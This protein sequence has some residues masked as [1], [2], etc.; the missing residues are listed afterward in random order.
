MKLQDAKLIS[1]AEDSYHIEMPSGRTLT[2]DKSK[3]SEK[4][5]ALVRSLRPPDTQKFDEGG[6]VS[7]RPL[8]AGYLKE[9]NSRYPSDPNRPND[10]HKSTRDIESDVE[11]SDMAPYSNHF[12]D[13]QLK[14]VRG[15]ADGGEAQNKPDKG[16]SINPDAAKKFVK[17]FNKPHTLA[18]GFENAKKELGFAD[19][20]EIPQDSPEQ[21]MAD[22]GTAPSAGA[23]PEMQPP[24]SSPQNPMQQ[25][26]QSF[27]NGLEQQKAGIQAGA[28]IAAKEGAAE[29]SAITAAQ[30]K[31]AQLPTQQEILD[32]YK[33]ADSQ[34]EQK[35]KSQQLD[36][37]RYWNNMST[38]SKIASGVALLL[39][40]FA[41]GLNGTNKNQVAE[42]IQGN[43]DKDIDAQKNDQSKTMNLWKMNR[44]ALGN[45]LA[46]NLA[47]QNQAYTAL[48]YN[49]EKAAAQFKG[50]MAQAN[51]Q[52]A[53]AMIQQ[54]QD[55]NRFKLSLMS[56]TKDIQPEQKV[57]FLVPEPHQKE[58]FG[59]IERAQDTK[60]MSSDI[61]KSFEQAAKEN[62]VMKTGAGWLRTPGSVYALHQ[63]LQPT[64]KDLEGTVRQAAM[65]NTF[66]NITPA[67]GDSEHTLK[68]KRDALMGYLQSKSSAPTA[69]GYGIDLGQ[70]SS[71]SPVQGAAET[72]SMNGVQYQK[73]AGG[74]QKV[75]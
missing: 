48:K 34:F 46:A 5:H 11:H 14:A 43:I 42:M 60:R 12:K 63:A 15:Y 73:V 18:E 29:T 27:N 2:V 9:V 59:E 23:S 32:R 72:K 33:S 66:K 62:T 56:N 39:G 16:P 37:N 61:V 70:Y 4:A 65:D 6:S 67:P 75:Q 68:T 20:G 40:G 49:I 64:F 74:W 38:G 44:E 69:K 50:P 22:L 58:V 7:A 41:G 35:L 3:L 25:K 55:E 13:K 26:A 19:G 54:K 36:P 53:I 57:Q 10:S 21:V 24:A 47:T 52:Q 1:E 30:D 51:A 31:V 71:T 17:G 45:D 28:D 8:D